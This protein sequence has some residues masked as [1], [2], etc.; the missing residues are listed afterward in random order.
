MHG[1]KPEHPQTARASIWQPNLRRLTL[2]LTL[3][4]VAG[5]FEA[6]AV[7]TVL[8]I[9]LRELGGLAYYGWTFSAFQLANVIGITLGGESDRVGISRLFLAGLALFCSGLALSGCAGSMQVIVAGRSLQGLGSGLLYTSAYAAISQAYTV[10]LQ[11]RMLAT[12]SSAWVIPG[13]VGPGVAGAL[14]EQLSWRWVFLGLVPVTLLAALLALPALAALPR[15]ASAAMSGRRLWLAAEL[16][17]GA[18]GA[19]LAPDLTHWAASLALAA[20]GGGL[21][22]HALRQLFPAGTLSARPGQPA[23]VAT[24]LLLTFSFFGAE[25]FVPLALSHVRH[26]PVWITGSALTCAALTWTTGAWLPVRLGGRVHRRRLV[27]AGVVLLALGLCATAALL[28]PGVPPWAAGLAW[29]LSGLGMGLAF[30]TTSAA[31]LEPAGPGEGGAASAALQLAQVLGAALSTGC[32]GAIVA[33]GFAGDPPVRGIASVDLLMLAACGLALL[34]TRGIA[35][36]A[37]QP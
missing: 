30:T 19:L 4:V 32:G 6:L 27:R 9:T 29:G 12:L 37:P 24:M 13:L 16:A 15:V 28:W 23:A 18:L 21:F 17:V 3:V 11:P 14:A 10:D 26:A 7:A 31:I 36:A 33:S 20:V 34:S 2:G 25:A 5:A 1:V 35:D 22:L 8:P